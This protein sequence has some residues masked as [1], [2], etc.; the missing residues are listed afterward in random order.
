M[1]VF[2]PK[3]GLGSVVNRYLQNVIILFLDLGAT[4]KFHSINKCERHDFEFLK[5]LSKQL[6]FA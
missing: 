2:R 1:Y 6:L 5:D 4:L 3:K